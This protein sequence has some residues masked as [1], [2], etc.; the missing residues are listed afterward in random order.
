MKL[1]LICLVFLILL[2]IILFIIQSIKIRK[3]SAKPKNNVHF[4]VARDKYDNVLCLYLGKP[5]RGVDTFHSCDEGCAVEVGNC[6][7]DFGL[8]PKDF[9]NLKW[10]DEPVE[11][12]L[13]LGNEDS[14]HN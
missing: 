14:K 1:L 10:E 8:N 9:E 13:N 5:L 2:F 11:V 3:L 6:F 4:Y 12:F 7:F